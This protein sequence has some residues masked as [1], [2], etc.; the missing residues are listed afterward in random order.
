[1]GYPSDSQQRAQQRTLYKH[2]LLLM[3]FLAFLQ[4]CREKGKAK[5]SEEFP[6]IRHS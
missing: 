4:G 2:T 1:M 3:F 5:I 6:Q